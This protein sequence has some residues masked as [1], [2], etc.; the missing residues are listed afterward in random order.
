[1]DDLSTSI[2]GVSYSEAINMTVNKKP[3]ECCSRCC[4]GAPFQISV[5]VFFMLAIQSYDPLVLGLAFVEIEPSAFECLYDPGTDKNKNGVEPEWHA[6]TKDEICS[7]NIPHTRYR[8]DES[9]PDYLH[10]WVEKFDF[11][12]EPKNKMGIF[13]FYF[14]LGIVV[15][16]IYISKVSDMYG[17]KAL[18]IEAMSATLVAQVVLII[19]EDLKVAQ[20]MMF[21][22]GSTFAGK[23]IIG[24]QYLIEYQSVKLTSVT[25]FIQ[26][27][28]EPTIIILITLWY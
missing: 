4:C 26:L 9:D 21:V 14:F 2:N 24:F 3:T 8:A 12:C 25:V 27:I 11:I 5:I 22:L 17:R 6:C 15:T 28:I 23:S 7:E 10:N 16:V 18:M 13:G 19:T 1:M 20:A